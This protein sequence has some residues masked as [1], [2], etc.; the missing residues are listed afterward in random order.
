MPRSYTMMGVLLV[1]LDSPNRP[2][3]VENIMRSSSHAVSMPQSMLQSTT[4]N[5]QMWRSRLRQPSWMGKNGSSWGEPRV[6]GHYARSCTVHSASFIHGMEQA[7]YLAATRSAASCLGSGPVSSIL[8][9]C[10]LIDKP[11]SKQTCEA[12]SHGE[13]INGPGRACILWQRHRPAGSI[14]ACVGCLGA[15]SEPVPP[16]ELQDQHHLLRAWLQFL[17]AFANQGAGW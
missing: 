9:L 1:Y 3:R 2:D 5:L 15:A 10:T 14:E 13:N 16:L 17:V 6:T 12:A 4:A 7:C 11:L 8:C